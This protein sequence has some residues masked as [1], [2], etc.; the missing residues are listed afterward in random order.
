MYKL[1]IWYLW[2]THSRHTVKVMYMKCVHTCRKYCITEDCFKAAISAAADTWWHSLLRHP[3]YKSQSSIQ[4]QTCSMLIWSWHTQR[5]RV[6]CKSIIVIHT[7]VRSSICTVTMLLIMTCL[8]HIAVRSTSFSLDIPRSL[9]GVS[10]ASYADNLT[11]AFQCPYDDFATRNVMS[12]LSI[13]ALYTGD[14]L[15]HHLSSVSSI[16]LGK[17]HFTLPFRTLMSVRTNALRYV[18]YCP[19]WNARHRR[20]IGA[21]DPVSVFAQRR[22]LCINSHHNLVFS[23]CLFNM[24]SVQ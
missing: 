2:V 24:W 13:T 12:P 4:L 1:Y 3:T 10:D 5:N 16:G 9:A 17:P 6:L 22:G 19:C 20:C 15:C 18:Q 7:A 8:Y 23:M 21:A 14:L 11:I